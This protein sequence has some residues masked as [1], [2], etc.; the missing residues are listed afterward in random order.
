MESDPR[1]TLGAD[2]R[3]VDYAYEPGRSIAVPASA[4]AEERD[5]IVADHKRTM[6]VIHADWHARKAAQGGYL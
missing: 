4:T 3:W 1:I 2:P 5:A 6:A